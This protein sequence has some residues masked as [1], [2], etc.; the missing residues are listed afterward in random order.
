ME[1]C[2]GMGGEL[3]ETLW[4]RIFRQTSVNDMVGLYYRLPDQEETVD[5]G[6]KPLE[7]ALC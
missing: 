6:F 1:L 3:A 4:V 5:K 7:E 2:L